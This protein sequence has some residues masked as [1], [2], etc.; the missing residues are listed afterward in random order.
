MTVQEL[1]ARLQKYPSDALV[2]IYNVDEEQDSHID[3]VE[4]RMPE[5]EVDDGFTFISS[6]HYCKGYSNAQEHW[7]QNGTEKPIVFLRDK[8]FGEV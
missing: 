7:S 4:A 6:P 2:L 3:I 8:Y 1:I 5:V